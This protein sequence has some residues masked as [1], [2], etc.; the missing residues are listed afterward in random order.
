[1]THFASNPWPHDAR[2]FQ[3]LETKET[4]QAHQR[5][6]ILLI[7]IGLLFTLVVGKIAY[8]MVLRSSD[9]EGSARKLPT[10]L[11]SRNN[12]LDRHGNILATTLIT[13]SAYA[14]P[15]DILN[16]EEAA[17]KLSKLFP[18]LPYKTLLEKLSSKKTFVWIKRNLTPQQQEDINKLGLPGVYFQR[19][20]K[21]VYPYDKLTAHVVGLTDVDGNGVAGIERHFDQYLRESDAKVT[22][23]LDIRAQHILYEELSKGMEKFSAIAAS[24]IILDTETSEVI[25]MVSLPDFDPNQSKQIDANSI[26]N[27]NTLGIYEMGSIFKI[28]TLAMA[29]DS[30][31][32]NLNSGYDTSKAFKV[33]KHKIKDFYGKNRWLSIP[34][35]FMYSSNI[36]SVKMALEVG[37]EKQREFLEKMGLLNATPLEL[38]ETG[39]PLAPQQWGDVGAATISYGYGVAISP[40]QMINGVASIVNGGLLRTPTLILGKNNDAPARRVISSNTSEKMRRLMHLSVKQGTGKKSDA[41][42]YL[43]G[44]KTGTANKTSNKGYVAKNYH[45]ALYV[46]AFPMVK[47]RYVILIMLDEPK[48]IKETFGF[49]TGGWTSAPIAGSI[50]KRIAPILGVL[51][52]D[53][54]SNAIQSAMRIS[55]DVIRG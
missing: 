39:K 16:P 52:V 43:V 18:G 32:I 6:L 47:P 42:G 40:L 3:S 21:R 55:Q 50:I 33:G 53:E 30:G 45:R 46:G 7:T 26:F 37:P 44:G 19:E 23:S 12:I 41:N 51:P 29:L 22:L 10:T 15:K 1:V 20:E 5:T 24:G 14:N 49:S 27:S 4:N 13:S 25:S 31:K 35:I 8:L 54:K 2:L 38:P 36:G 48:G 11:I 34:E 28:F 17:E 9:D